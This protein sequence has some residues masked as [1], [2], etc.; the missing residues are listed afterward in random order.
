[1]YYLIIT[2]DV[3]T[4]DMSGLKVFY[5]TKK[6]AEKMAELARSIEWTETVKIEK[7]GNHKTRG[8]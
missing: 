4:L 8:N 7:T 2:T 3:G 1:M 6:E 5:R